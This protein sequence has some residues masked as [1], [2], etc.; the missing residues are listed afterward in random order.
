[1]R[2]YIF[3]ALTVAKVYLV[4]RFFGVDVTSFWLWAGCAFSAGILCGDVTANRRHEK[5]RR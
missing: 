1:M 5:R 2:W 3:A 4:H